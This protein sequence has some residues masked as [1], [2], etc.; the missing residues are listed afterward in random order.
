MEPIK[1]T[2]APVGR[3]YKAAKQHKLRIESAGAGRNHGDTVPINDAERTIH[4]L[5]GLIGDAPVEE[6]IAS[7]ELQPRT[8]DAGRRYISDEQFMRA[9]AKFGGKHAN[10]D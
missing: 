4:E 8:N 10:E 9:L 1:S 5:K 6:M 2:P 3:V 7:G